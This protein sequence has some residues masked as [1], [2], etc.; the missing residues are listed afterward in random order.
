[1]PEQFQFEIA[2]AAAC[3]GQD[4]WTEH[5]ANAFLLATAVGAFKNYNVS[6]PEQ[7]RIRYECPHYHLIR[8]NGDKYPTCF[9]FSLEMRTRQIGEGGD[10]SEVLY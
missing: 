5:Q 6:D 10:I 9:F 7:S 2:F 1:M 3:S 8:K 4:I